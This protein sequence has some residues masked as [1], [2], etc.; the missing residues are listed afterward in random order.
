MRQEKKINELRVNVTDLV[1]VFKVEEK[2]DAVRE[3]VG[4]ISHETASSSIYM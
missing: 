4:K 2:D 3:D 1:N